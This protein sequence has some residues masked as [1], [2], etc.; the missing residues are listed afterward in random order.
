MPAESTSNWIEL[1]HQS[2]IFLPW[3]GISGRPS[4]LV[5]SFPFSCAYLSMR[6][7]TSH[8]VARVLSRGGTPQHRRIAKSRK[9]TAIKPQA[10]ATKP[11][12]TAT[13]S[14]TFRLDSCIVV[15]ITGHSFLMDRDPRGRVRAADRFAGRVV[16]LPRVRPNAYPTSANAQAQFSQGLAGKATALPDRLPRSLV[17]VPAWRHALPHP[18]CRGSWRRAPNDRPS[19]D[20]PNPAQGALTPQASPQ[21]PK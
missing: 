11:Q 4:R 12:A 19:T 3:A 8:I 15:W 18:Y 20:L 5:G 7:L 9:Q 16:L 10:T 6:R 1:P 14:V 21:L 17:A 2:V 13:K